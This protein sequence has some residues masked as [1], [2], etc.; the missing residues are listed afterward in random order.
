MTTRRLF[1]LFAFLACVSLAH[2]KGSP[3]LILIT[4]GGITQPI[5]ITDSTSLK[6]FDPWDGQFAD[7]KQESLADVPCARRSFSVKFYMKWPG[8]KSSESN[9]DLQMVYATRYCSTGATG[10]VYLPGPGQ[11]IYRDNAFT[12]MRGD[13]D[14]KWHPATSEWDSLLMNLVAAQDPQREP[15]MI[16][17]AGGELQHPIEITD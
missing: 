5:Q 4:G 16:M 12:I 7:W 3:D 15:D 17:I 11:A 6:A 1:T 9:G 8:R 14:G 13:A 2:A 10:Y